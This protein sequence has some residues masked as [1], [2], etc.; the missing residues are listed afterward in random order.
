MVEVEKLIRRKNTLITTIHN[1]VKANEDKI[2][3]IPKFRDEPVAYI[4]ILTKKLENLNELYDE[5]VDKIEDEALATVEVEKGYEFELK[6]STHINY[7]KE[8]LSVKKRENAV[9]QEIKSKGID[10]SNVVRLP[11]LEITKFSGCYTKW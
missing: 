7:L 10:N 3:D 8:K 11:K 5:I 9:V 4:S 2:K 6:V 1:A